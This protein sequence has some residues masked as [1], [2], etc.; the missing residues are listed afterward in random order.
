MV[1]L[2]TELTAD[3]S[4]VRGDAIQL[5]QVV[6]N[7][8]LNALDAVA[9]AEHDK[10]ITIGTRERNVDVELYVH[11]SGPSLSAEVQDNLFTPFYSTKPDGLGMGL[12]I[13]RM[14]VLRHDGAVSGCN[15]DTGVVFSVILPK[16]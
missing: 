16:A 5:Q 10:S 2:E 6:M 3:V 1:R 7:L 8:V 13:V 4:P 9:S 12:A 14:I 15:D 11:N